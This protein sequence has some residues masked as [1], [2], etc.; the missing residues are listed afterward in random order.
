MLVEDVIEPLIVL[1]LLG[2]IV[3]LLVDIIGRLR[4]RKKIVSDFATLISIFIVGWLSTEL[5]EKLSLSPHEQIFDFA[6]L[7]VLVGFAGALT[8]RWKWAVRQAIR[9]FV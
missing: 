1:L 2:V 4:E 6:H 7:L 5:V 3:T 8:L 9:E